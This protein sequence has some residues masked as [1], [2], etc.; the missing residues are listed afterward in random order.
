MSAPDHY[1]VIGHPVDH[2]RSPFIH[3]RFARQVGHDI[4]YGLIDAA[5]T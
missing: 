5:T 4:D 1:A 2:S 3:E